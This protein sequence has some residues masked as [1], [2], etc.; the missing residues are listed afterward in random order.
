MIV[1]FFLFLF[2]LF[3]LTGCNLAPPRVVETE[4]LVLVSVSEIYL[5]DCEDVAPPSPAEYMAKG[6]DEREDLLTRT[7]IQQYRALKN[8]TT[9][10][11]MLRE[12]LAKQKAIVDKH[13]ADEAA[14]VAKATSTF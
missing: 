4:K 12:D 2:M 10:K 11:R 6:V 9:D 3:G 1:R 8:C 14:R 13:N 5:Q 7:V